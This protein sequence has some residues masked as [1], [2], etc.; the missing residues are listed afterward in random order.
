MDL[1]KDSPGYNRE[2]PKLPDETVAQLESLV[3]PVPMIPV[4]ETVAVNN[5]QLQAEVTEAS[6]TEVSDNTS[7][8]GGN[9][10]SFMAGKIAQADSKPE[11]SRRSTR[12]SSSDANF[13]GSSTSGGSATNQGG[14][15]RR[16]SRKQVDED[17]L[18]DGTQLHAAHHGYFVHRDYAA[19]F[20]RW[21]FVARWIKPGMRIMDV[22]CG[23]DLPFARVL[24][25]PNVFKNCQPTKVVA[26]DWNEVPRSFNPA[27]LDVVDKFDFCT[28]WPELIGS[29]L[30]DG[31][32]MELPTNKFDAI[33]NL[34][35]IEHMRP[36]Q[37]DQLLKGLHYCL[38]DDGYLFLSTP[39]FNGSAAANHLHEYT[40][41][42]L[43]EKLQ[44]NGF[45]LVARFGTFANVVDLKKAMT[46]D[47]LRLFE[48]LSA[49]Y[50]HD[51]L[52][53]F[54]APKYPDY[55]RNNFWVLKK[56]VT[57]TWPG[58]TDVEVP[59]PPSETPAIPAVPA[60]P[61]IPGYEGVHHPVPPVPFEAGLLHREMPEDDTDPEELGG[62]SVDE[63]A[64]QIQ[65]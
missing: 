16:R 14:T 43:W 10:A 58:F 22:G 41:P 32:W 54:F 38:K 34:E 20:F 60:V 49:F 48:E 25:A 2:M 27:W 37:G 45:A 30:Q 55:S 21:G 56:M 64:E 35:V 28:R 5:L 57:G 17:R 12:G 24:S 7:G 19:H 39:V 11:R 61:A 46:P 29:F 3:P 42:E 1:P 65:G 4:Q 51:I 18:Y 62:Y 6:E 15:Q 50:A 36:D 44:R 31:S 47:E 59:T 40:I 9:V 53:C 52:S 23:Q 63:V 13:S 33:I 8:V 26:V